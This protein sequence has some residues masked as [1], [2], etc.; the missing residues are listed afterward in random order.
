M[1]AA[2]AAPTAVGARGPAHVEPDG[3]LLGVLEQRSM[4]PGLTRA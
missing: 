4:D 1:G 2:A 3:Q